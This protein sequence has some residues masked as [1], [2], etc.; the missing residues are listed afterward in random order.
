[1][2]S[3][4]IHALEMLSFYTY[5]KNTVGTK[6]LYFSL[7]LTSDLHRLCIP[8]CWVSLPR[9]L[10]PHTEAII[11][12]EPLAERGKKPGQDSWAGDCS[13]TVSRFFLV[14]CIW[15]DDATLMRVIFHLIWDFHTWFSAER[16]LKRC[17]VHHHRASKNKTCEPCIGSLTQT[18]R[19]KKLDSLQ[20]NS[21]VP[22]LQNKLLRSAV[23]DENRCFPASSVICSHEWIWL[24]WC[25]SSSETFN[26]LKSG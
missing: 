7:A 16:L 18:A 13:C 17:S 4:N 5:K 11:M 1:M 24:I 10:F 3:D 15:A 6:T 9:A 22:H 14:W 25:Y 23:M 20:R 19:S 21:E 2:L 26:M 12:S 8:V